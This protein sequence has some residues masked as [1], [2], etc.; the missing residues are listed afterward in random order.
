[1]MYNPE[2]RIS[3]DDYIVTSTRNIINRKAT[4][5][6]PSALEIPMG[7]C[8]IGP[9]VTIRADLAPCRL[10]KYTF[11]EDDTILE[12][13]ETSGENARRIPMTV[14]AYCSIGKRCKIES[15]VIGLGCTIGDGSVLSKR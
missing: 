7:R 14:G 9:G 5:N 4:I 6:K 11:I 1:M 15:A 8:F 12:P 3:A 13:C 2:E 10:D